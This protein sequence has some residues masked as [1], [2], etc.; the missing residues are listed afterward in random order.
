M[1]QLPPIA[2][3]ERRRSFSLLI[4]A[5]L[6]QG[7][8]LVISALAV[9]EAIAAVRAG[10]QNLPLTAL[11]MMAGAG[12]GLA[13][14]RYA[15]RV[16]AE[17]VAQHYVAKLREL[18]FLRFSKAPAS[19]LSQQRTGALSL[20]YVGDLTAIR[21]WVGV[22]LARTISAGIML[23]LAFLVLLAIDLRLGL[24]AGVPIMLALV[25]MLR[26]GPPLRDAQAEVRKRRSRLAAAMT[27]RL[28]QA[29]ALRRAGRIGIEKRSLR[30]QSAEIVS[31]A[32]HRVQL[33]AIIRAMPDASSG[34]AG[35][36]TIW[37]C[38]TYHVPIGET[39]AAL[40]TLSM[41]V[42]PMRHIADIRDRHSAWLVASEK[43]QRALNTPQIKRLGREA[44]EARDGRAALMVRHLL[45]DDI[46]VSLKLPR[47][48][49][50]L[51]VAENSAN[52]GHLLRLAG[53]LEAPKGGYFRV[54]GRHPAELDPKAIL[55]LG[56][57]SPSLRGSLRRDVLLGTGRTIDDD[58]ILSVL[59][60][61]GLSP[62]LARIGGLDGRIDEGRRNLSAAEQ[63]SIFLA[64][65]LVA[66]PKLAL[67]DADEIGFGPDDI[68][69]LT[70]HFREIGS[71]ALI[72]TRFGGGVLG[73][74]LSIALKHT[75]TASERRKTNNIKSTE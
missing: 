52:A 48:A 13:L 23:P 10:D 29:T 68:A 15:E 69:M 41:I 47:G 53:G 72:A 39:V 11:A 57:A 74:E 42:R 70:A 61:L 62:L 59:E 7:A 19:W 20:R 21:N 26:L 49:I 34:V 75:V 43:L 63:R 17:H 66:K 30:M 27:E 28:Q 73:Q 9:R 6:G 3:G 12:V 31:A 32:M 65:G 67:I 54:L 16:L 2:Q 46:P 1:N 60:N 8:M 55:Y 33:S 45:I 44:R 58:E 4:A 5:A 18:L 64:R 51:L 36:A 22:G 50:R 40:L 38:L 56:S 25:V 35:A 71:A 24:A 37:V 14:L